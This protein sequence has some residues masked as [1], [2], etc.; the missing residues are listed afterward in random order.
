MTYSE[1]D[2]QVKEYYTSDANGIVGGEYS[3]R[4]SKRG[5]LL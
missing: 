3:K 2:K 1:L 4:I 5:K